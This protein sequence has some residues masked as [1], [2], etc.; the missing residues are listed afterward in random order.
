MNRKELKIRLDEE[1][2]PVFWYS[3]DGEA[4]PNKSILQKGG[5]KKG[6]WVIYGIDERGNKSNYKEFYYEDEACEYFYQMMKK[7]K[8]RVDRINETPLSSPILPK[9]QNT[10]IVS[11]TGEIIV[12]KE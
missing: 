1:N 12:Q 8:E 3:L 2:I 10:F 7:E 9:E 4:I 6:Y 11:N 5:G